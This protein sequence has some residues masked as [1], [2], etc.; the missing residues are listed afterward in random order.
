MRD[1][2]WLKHVHTLY[3]IDNAKNIKIEIPQRKG[4]PKLRPGVNPTLIGAWA[5][6]SA[7]IPDFAETDYFLGL[8]PEGHINR[9]KRR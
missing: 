7:P 1:R 4:P 9:K 8:Y 5:I 3:K 6:A 2:K